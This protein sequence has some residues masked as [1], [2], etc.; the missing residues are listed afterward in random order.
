MPELPEAETICRTL[1]P[2]IRGKLITEIH[3]V[4]PYLLKETQPEALERWKGA[5]LVE[6]R[7][8]GKMILLDSDRQETLLIHLKMTGQL[9]LSSVK[10]SMDKHV[11]LILKLEENEL[12][13]RFRDPRKFGY[14]KI[15]ETSREGQ[16]QPLSQ[17][18]PEPFDLSFGDFLNLFKKHKGKIKPLL[19]RQDFMAGLGNIYSDEILHRAR[20]NPEKPVHLLT[21][22]ELVCLYRA[23]L[24]V[25]T[26][27]I[28]RRGTSVRNYRDGLGE[29]GNFQNYLRIYGREG[30]PCFRCHEL[31]KRKKIG[32]RSTFFCPQCQTL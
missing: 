23:M 29:T 18:G 10:E 12:E 17:L 14:V 6:V 2:R 19:L 9:Y 26:E 28:D 24:R 15:F 3:L 21:R 7:R 8:R 5:R 30:E 4:W 25:L 16:T 32:S 1:R 27:A 31:I 22:P 11:R 20:I 13:L